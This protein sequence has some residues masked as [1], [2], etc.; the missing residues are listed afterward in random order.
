VLWTLREKVRY[1]REGD[2]TDEV[3]A[4]R[5]APGSSLRIGQPI[6]IVVAVLDRGGGFPFVDGD[7]DVNINFDVDID[8]PS[9]CSG[10][11]WC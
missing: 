11:R 2:P 7:S 5:P 10:T 3:L 9:F 1:A 6:S 8:F 4:Q